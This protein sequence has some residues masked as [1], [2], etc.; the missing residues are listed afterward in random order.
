M[1]LSSP[2]LIFSTSMFHSFFFNLTIFDASPINTSSP[3]VSTAGQQL[4]SQ[5]YTFI[6]SPDIRKRVIDIKFSF[7]IIIIAFMKFH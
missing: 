2:D 5:I 7:S 6:G 3:T 4:F 1:V